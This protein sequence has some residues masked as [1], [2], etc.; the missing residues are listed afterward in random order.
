M[1][2]SISQILKL[3]F[4][5]L[6]LRDPPFPLNAIM[7]KYLT[8]IL[9]TKTSVVRLCEV[10]CGVARY[11]EVLQGAVR[12]CGVSLGLLMHTVLSSM[13]PQ[14]HTKTSVVRCCEVLLLLV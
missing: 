7:G 4:H 10:L 6:N 9:H 8:P 14:L 2:P 1:N 13:S 5:D 11:C 12:C 3:I